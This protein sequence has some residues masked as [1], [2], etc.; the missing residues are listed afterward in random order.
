[1]IKEFTLQ[2]HMQSNKQESAPGATTNAT[3]GV[4]PP[5]RLESVLGIGFYSAFEHAA[6]GMLLLDARNNCLAAN[7]SLCS[8]LECSE[9]ELLEQGYTSFIHSSEREDALQCFRQLFAGESMLYSSE[10][11]YVTKTGRQLSGLMS[12][13]VVLNT[14]E[15]PLWVIVQ[16]QDMSEYKRAETAEREQRA[17]AEALRDVASALSST[18]NYEQ[19]LDRLLDNVGRVVPHDAA[20]VMLVDP[21]TEEAYVVRARG[22]ASRGLEGW[23]NQLRFPV[24]NVKGLHQMM[25]VGQPLVVSDV[26]ADPGWVVFAEARWLRSYA[27]APIRIKGQTVGFLNFDSATP[28]FFT[29]AHLERLQAFADQAAI[30]IDNA[31]LFEATRRSVERLTMLHQAAVALAKA[32]SVEALY[33]EVLHWACALAGASAATLAFFDGLAHL[34]LVAVEGMREDVVGTRIG[35][36]EDVN[37]Q[38]ARLRRPVQIQHYGEWAGRLPAFANQDI[39]SAVALPLIW[40]DRLVGTLGVT[41]HTAREFNEDDIHVLD[42]FASLAAA[43]VE[44]RRAMAEAQAREAEA[45]TLSTR[46]ANAQEEER[47]RI[48]EQLHDAIG[49]RLVA[50]QK[51][52]ESVL[53]ALGTDH[54][55]AERLSDNLKVLQETH[56]QARWLATDLSTKVLDD[57]GISPAAKQYIDR[58]STATGT[59]IRLHVTGHV[60]RLSTEIERVAYRS[61]QE[62]VVNALRHADG[63]EISVQIHFGGKALRL[64]VQ[65]NGRG[66]DT[67]TLQNTSKG[68]A[69]GLPELRRQVEALQGE[70]VLESMPGQGTL[71]ALSLPFRVANAPEKARTRVL[72]VDDHEISRQ[73]L[74]MMLAQSAGFTCIGEAADGLQAVRQ[75]ELNHPDL[76]LMDVKLPRL[77]GIDAARQITRRFPHVRIVMLSYYSDEAYLQQA[78]QAGAQGYL[79][80][81]D[82]GREMM[83]GIQAV[84]EGERYISAGLAEVWARLQVQPASSDPLETLTTRE[85]EVFGL[86]VAGNT[87]RKVGEN[88]GISV[89]TVEVYRKN[90]MGKL[91]VKNLAQLVQFAHDKLHE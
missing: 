6:I 16:I 82:E 79:L 50:L 89:R 28:G 80:K 27:A 3:P 90:I 61:L 17:L 58:L 11:R 42:L 1:M 57:L 41:D 68:A 84:C 69:L 32:E 35:I 67:E 59:N 36:G 30:A 23:I 65:D 71:V 75:V 70:F 60:R 73:G 85:R 83:A 54:P 55:L 38:A 13:S 66:F 33:R 45:N 12:A 31:R 26:W 44:Q 15:K 91:G 47:T 14:D 52:T 46:L 81:S 88:L 74:R 22:Y 62:S 49:Y 48:A 51:N 40:Q 53:S 87:N 29:A 7:R 9:P 78:F 21:K 63:T 5:P 39:D 2:G 10:R 18:L 24:A 64:T 25:Q 8:M 86:I 56:Q 4:N 20:N 37:G 76:V 19:V 72:L 77:N 34:V 43:A